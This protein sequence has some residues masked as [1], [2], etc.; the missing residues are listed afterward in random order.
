MFRSSIWL[1]AFGFSLISC[2]RLLSDEKTVPP[3]EVGKPFSKA[4]AILRKRNVTE[5]QETAENPDI[6]AVAFD[7]D[8]NMAAKLFYSR[9]LKVVTELH[10]VTGPEAGDRSTFRAK[11]IQLEAAGSY[12]IQFLPAKAPQP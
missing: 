6:V 1:L 12:S 7:L 5:W 8:D 9:S 3:I 2:E 4:T 11:K 10:V